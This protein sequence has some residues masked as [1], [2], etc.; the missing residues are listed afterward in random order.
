MKRRIFQKNLKLFQKRR[1]L[2]KKFKKTGS[3][4]YEIEGFYERLKIFRVEAF[5]EAKNFS[6]KSE[7]FYKAKNFSKKVQKRFSTVSIR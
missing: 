3:F 5:Y 6:K 4:L 1:I 2:Q 7:A